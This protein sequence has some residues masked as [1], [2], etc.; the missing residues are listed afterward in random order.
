MPRTT[1]C[2]KWIWTS[3]LMP[4]VAYQIHDVLAEL[5]Q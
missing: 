1:G 5:R 2:E 4:L 3:G